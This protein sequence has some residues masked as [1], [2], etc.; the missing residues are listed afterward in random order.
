MIRERRY[1]SLGRPLFCTCPSKKRSSFALRRT[2]TTWFRFLILHLLSTV[3]FTPCA[4][5]VLFFFLMIKAANSDTAAM[6]AMIFFFKLP[7]PFA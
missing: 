6:P 5:T 3:F 4:Y 1:S 7:P 2:G